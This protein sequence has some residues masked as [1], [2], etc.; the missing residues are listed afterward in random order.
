MIAWLIEVGSPSTYYCGPGDWCSN[1]NH[2]HK[3]SSEQEA[4]A[5]AAPMGKL[6]GGLPRCCEH[7]WD[8]A[9]PPAA[10]PPDAKPVAWIS[11]KDRTPEI[12]PL[13]SDN[14]LCRDLSGNAVVLTW[15]AE[16]GC[17][18]SGGGDTQAVTHWMEIL[19]VDAAP[20]PA[21]DAKPEPV[22]WEYKHKQAGS[23]TLTHQP[24]D[25]VVE[26]DLTQ[27]T[28]RPLYAAPQPPVGKG[29]PSLDHSTARA[30]LA[31][32]QVAVNTGDAIP[33][34]IHE[35]L[36]RDAKLEGFREA[37]REA[38]RRFDNASN[39]VFSRHDVAQELE[40]MADTMAS[41]HK[42]GRE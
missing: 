33:R 9:A 8:D 39:E 32:M 28:W 12:T 27:Y 30:A 20:Q 14:F 5:T 22:A 23:T 2:A 29:E 25:R 15:I 3:F 11:I 7:M 26:T 24:P 35:R 16:N 42:R 40:G 19:P 10:Q 31:G 4:Q 13:R 21:P 17:F 37:F 41:E 18:T 6:V 38:A 36:I 34:E 1:P